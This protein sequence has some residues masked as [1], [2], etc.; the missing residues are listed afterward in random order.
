MLQFKSLYKPFFVLL[1]LS[2][3]VNIAFAQSSA[4]SEDRKF[5][6]GAHFSLLR[7]QLNP[8]IFPGGNEIN[9][10]PGVGSRIAYQINKHVSIEGEMTFFP[11]EKSE[12]YTFGVLGG[13]GYS[14]TINTGHRTQ[15]LFGVKAGKRFNKVGVFGKFRPGF[16]TS[17]KTSFT[18]SDGFGNISSPNRTNLA[19]DLGG[20]FEVYHSSRLFTRLDVGDTIIRVGNTFTGG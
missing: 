15:G 2:L 11:R 14:L 3:A 1:L 5:E 18:Y 13:G 12:T 20:V 9:N 10:D 4:Q 7:H 17:G 6:V 16:L 8:N 19:L